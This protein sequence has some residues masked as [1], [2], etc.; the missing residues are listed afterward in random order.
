MGLSHFD[1]FNI[2][3]D[4]GIIDSSEIVA[5]LRCVC[6]KLS[7]NQTSCEVVAVVILHDQWSMMDDDDG[8]KRF[9]NHDHRC[10]MLDD[11]D[12]DDDD[13]STGDDASNSPDD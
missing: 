13:D 6:L 5:S 9:I 11:D 10:L 4:L 7:A 1:P 3:D 12:D 2:C 8:N